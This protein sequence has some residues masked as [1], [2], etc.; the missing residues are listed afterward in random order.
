MRVGEYLA[1]LFSVIRKGQFV[2]LFFKKLFETRTQRKTTKCYNACNA[3][4]LGVLRDEKNSIDFI[5]SNDTLE[6]MRSFQSNMST[7]CRLHIV[8]DI[9]FGLLF[10]EL[11]FHDLLW[12][13]TEQTSL[14]LTTK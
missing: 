4:N 2:N 10:A 8:F 1:L 3:G 12:L 7:S 9:A 6:Y 11:Q 14:R 5:R 13:Q